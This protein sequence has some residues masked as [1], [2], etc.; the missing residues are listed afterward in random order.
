MQQI[1]KNRKA[2]AYTQ[3]ILVLILLSLVTK[4]LKTG[5]YYLRSRA[6]ADAIK[7]TVDTTMIKVVALS[8]KLK[9]LLNPITHAQS[10]MQ[11]FCRMIRLRRLLMTRILRWPK[12]YA[13]QPTATSAWL[14]EVDRLQHKWD[15]FVCFSWCLKGSC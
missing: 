2:Y 3:S 14:V 11:S 9:I 5:M 7:F 10:I 13:L 8:T 12:W 6:A 15:L 4:G 1:Q